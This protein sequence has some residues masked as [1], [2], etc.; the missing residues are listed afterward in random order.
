M[1]AVKFLGCLVLLQ[2][3]WLSCSDGE[4]GP[5]NEGGEVPGPISNPS[6]ENLSGGA[7]ITY[8]L[9]QNK[10]ILHVK[11][12]FDRNGEEVETI[13][14]YYNNFIKVE[15]F[16]NT[17]ERV[18]KL[19]VVSRS[20]KSSEP[21]SV[22]IHPTAPPIEKVFTSLDPKVSWGGFVS[23]YTNEEEESV[24]IFAVKF[25]VE[26]QLW[27]DIGGHYTSSATGRVA[28][29]GMEDLETKFGLYVR[30]RWDN[31]SDTLQ[32]ELTPWF[33]EELD[34]TKIMDARGRYP[35]P[36]I[37]PLPMSGRPLVEMVTYQP[38]FPFSAMFDF[39][40]SGT[41]SMFHSAISVDQPSWLP[42]DLGVEAR[43]SRYKIW[44][45][46]D[47]DF[48]FSVSNPRE[49]EL[50]G[51]NTPEDVNS[52]IKL[53]HRVMVK[54]S[55]L[56]FAMLSQEDT[57]VAEAGQ[58]YEFEDGIPAVRYIAWKHINSWS[59][60]RAPQGGFHLSELT[61]FGQSIQ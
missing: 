50:W 60:A 61:F 52:W 45:R 27:E 57:E 24:A 44:Q 34:R 43:L 39:N 17:S 11:A 6:V 1:N 26:N 9:P 29:R 19:Y 18:V 21:V 16:P 40:T 55:G 51:T 14:S 35:V 30:D 23:R 41:S 3:M 48:E 56:P 7:R 15:G 49:W 25:N 2:G 5:I 31:H 54:P 28:I 22:V 20:G 38:Q 32:F 10:D 8:T 33:E 4:F 36:Q 13:T 53:D 47:F 37:A 12:V 46:A 58:E 42:M 59:S